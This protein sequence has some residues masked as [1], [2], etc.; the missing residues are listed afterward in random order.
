LKTIT[1]VA[2]LVPLALAFPVQ[3]C[4]E[5]LVSSP[6]IRASA[7]FMAEGV[8][9]ATERDANKT[10]NIMDPALL[11]HLRIV[12]VLKGKHR[13]ALTV[14][15]SSCSVPGFQVGRKVTVVRYRSGEYDV[16]ERPQ[17]P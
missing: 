10:P 1:A 11:L 3:A 12:K 6:A 15:T 14:P 2:A 17:R 9:A 16:V 4:Q 5:A 8:V 13:T 7:T